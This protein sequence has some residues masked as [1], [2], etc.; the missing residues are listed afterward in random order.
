MKELEKAYPVCASCYQ[1]GKIKK[2]SARI[3]E[4][5]IKTKD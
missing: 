3:V 2:N 4:D 1:E 5:Y